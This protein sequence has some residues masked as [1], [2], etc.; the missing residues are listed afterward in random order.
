MND[1]RCAPLVGMALTALLTVATAAALAQPTLTSNDLPQGGQAY[2]RANAVP[3]LLADIETEGPGLTWDFSTLI[4]TG[5][6]ETEYFP[7]SAASFTTQFIFSSADHFTAFELPDLGIENPLP[8]SGATTYHEFGSSAYRIIGLG[9]T[10][11][12]VDLPVI[13]EDDEELLPLPLTYGATLDGTSAFEVDLPELLFYGTEQVT[14]I[15]VD[16]WGTLILPGATYECLRVRRTIAAQD[17]V[18]LP[19]AELGFSLPRE[20]TTYEWY[21]AGEGMPVLSVQMLAG[22]PTGCQYKPGEDE[23]IGVE[24]WNAPSYAITPNPAHLG[25]DLLLDGI[26]ESPSD[27]VVRDAAGRVWLDA[28]LEVEEGRMLVP[29]AAWPAGVYLVSVAGAPATRCIIR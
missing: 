25:Q 26:A 29:S 6:Q 19:A 4:S 8:F 14:N 9:I 10:T 5:T 22:I 11:D 28:V 21:A 24:E 7:M 17:S 15:A 13:Y 20:G 18:N 16:A 23:V 2:L 3:P 12:F 1:Q 27:I